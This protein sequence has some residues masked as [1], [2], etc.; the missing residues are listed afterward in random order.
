M[1]KIVSICIILLTLSSCSVLRVHKMDVEQGNLLTPE[2]TSQIHTGMS[3]TRV[4]E[5][6]GSPVLVN[7]FSN[8]RV[9]YVYTYKPGY[10]AFQEKYMTLT[11]RKGVLK[12]I[13]GNMYSTYLKS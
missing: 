13:K 5:I 7:T 2:L 10:G 1:K 3:Q 4:Q 12:E 11:F 8:N 9:D 6:L